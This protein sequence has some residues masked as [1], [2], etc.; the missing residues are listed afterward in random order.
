MKLK[1]KHLKLLMKYVVIEMN[2]REKELI[3]IQEQLNL[4]VFTNR[5]AQV[6]E[7]KT[8]TKDQLKWIENLKSELEICLKNA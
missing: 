1:K 5:V 4:Y 8:F 2:E 3:N 7:M 6:T